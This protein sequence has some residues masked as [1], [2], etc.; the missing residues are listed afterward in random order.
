MGATFGVST[1]VFVFCKYLKILYLMQLESLT[2]C[3]EGEEGIGK[4]LGPTSHKKQWKQQKLQSRNSLYEKDLKQAIL[5][6][7]KGSRQILLC[8]FC[9]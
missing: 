2:I 5:S 8:G 1:F 6:P 4:L 7:V 3:E 9:P